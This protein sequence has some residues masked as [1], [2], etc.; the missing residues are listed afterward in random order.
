MNIF[1]KIEELF[2]AA[3]NV[4]KN[5][6]YFYFHNCLYEFLWKNNSRRWEERFSTYDIIRTYGKEYK[7]I[8][9]GDASMSPYEILM[10]GG[11]NEHYNEETG[12][13][14]LKGL[15][16]NGQ[17]IYGLIQHQLITGIYQNQLL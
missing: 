17:I 4:F 16:N 11:G 13:F 10:P 9:V 14:G 1:L 6:Q 2:S 7:T 5:L 3:K 8:F 12:K 15:L